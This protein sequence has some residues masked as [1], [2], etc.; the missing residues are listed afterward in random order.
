MSGAL[1]AVFQNQRS[2][3]PPPGQTLYTTGSNTFV[4]PAGVTSISVVTVGSGAFR[5]SGGGALAYVNNISVTPGESLTAVVST[6]GG[7]TQSSYLA[8]GATK[9]VQA[10]SASYGAGNGYCF[11]GGSV[12]VGTGG[13][14][15]C[16]SCSCAR[17]GGGAGGYSGDGGNGGAASSAGQNGSGGGGGG[18]GGVPSGVYYGGGGGGGVGVLGSGSNGTGGSAG[19]TTSGGSGGTGG[20]SGA[21]GG[22]GSRFYCCGNYEAVPGRGGSY[23]GGAGGGSYIADSPSGGAVRIIWPGNTRSF[24]STN[25]GNL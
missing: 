25:T 21:S 19:T 10:G 9:L 2:F 8:R 4:V 6:T 18:G 24:P 12:V 5:R 16:S 7:N 20:S 23:G 13:D 11:V 1:Q 22:S 14:G 17:G 3:G 15:G